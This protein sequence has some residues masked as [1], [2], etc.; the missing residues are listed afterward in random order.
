MGH[1]DAGTGSEAQASRIACRER[2]TIRRNRA[3]RGLHIRVDPRLTLGG[4]CG[5]G[6]ARLPRDDR[7][8]SAELDHHQELLERVWATGR[9]PSSGAG[10]P[11]QKHG[12]GGGANGPSVA[13]GGWSDPQ[14]EQPVGHI[15]GRVET[16][17]ALNGRVGRRL[18]ENRTPT[19]CH[20]V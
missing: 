4:G 14:Q 17:F 11:A 7:R 10:K 16:Q 18:T 5:G 6:D 8:R 12:C 15:E 2:S 1:P 9:A 20:R 13:I 19:G 3:R